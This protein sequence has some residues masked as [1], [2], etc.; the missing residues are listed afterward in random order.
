MH[1]IKYALIGRKLAH[2]CSP[3]LHSLLHGYDY[4]LL[5]LEPKALEPFIR[6][7]NF[8]GLNVTIP[9]KRDV[10]PLCDS[11]SDRARR[12]GAVNTIVHRPDGSLF[13][14]NTDYAGFIYS[15]TRAGIAFFGEKVLVLGD[16]GASRSVCCALEDM[17]TDEITVISRNGEHGYSDLPSYIHYTRIVNTTPVG[18]FPNAGAEPLI[19]LRDFPNCG[20]VADV[21]YNPLRTRL[22]QEAQALGIPATG[23]LPML[24]AQAKYAGD[25]FTGQ[26]LLEEATEKALAA[27]LHTR[28]NIALIGM[29]GC[30]KSTVGQLLAEQ[31]GLL[32]VDVDTELELRTGRRIPELF[33]KDGE[34]NFR[35]LESETLADLCAH[36][37]QVI[38]A[39][40]GAVLRPENRIALRWNSRVVWIQR[41]LSALETEGRP[42]SHE[43]DAL[44]RL[45]AEREPLYRTVADLFVKNDS[46]SPADCMTA[47]LQKLNFD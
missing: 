43:A 23:G 28:E 47:L 14:D 20:G 40:G 2:S 36:G 10:M 38:A 21:I 44:A 26:P 33:A 46:V 17:G 25:L 6:A 12:I 45:W 22:V 5:E 34:A 18:M 32:F 31:L 42:L 7:K 3:E 11:L 24:A 8:C 29:P 35:D 37:G 1:E 19:N 16:G 39:G 27:L 13:G 4:R 41:D 9:Y 30:G 15:C